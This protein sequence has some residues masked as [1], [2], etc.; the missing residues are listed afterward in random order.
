[1]IFNNVHLNQVF[2]IGLLGVLLLIQKGNA[3]QFKVG[4]SGTWS[5]PS[6][7]NS[8]SYNQWAERSRFQIG[9]TLVFVYQGDKDSVLLVNK[10]D[11]NN[12]NTDNPINKFTDGHTEFKFDH[13]GPHYFI[14]GV[15]D[16]CL[17]NE[18]L[19][20]VV[21]ADRGNRSDAAAAPAPTTTTS[22]PPPPSPTT[23]PPSPTAEVS[24]P[25][26]APAGNEAPSPPAS[27]E[28]NPTPAPSDQTKHKNG[29]SSIVKSFIAHPM[30]AFLGSCLLLVFF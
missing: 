27:V 23:S 9:D 18:K 3:Y 7:P 11:Y 6:D 4:G 14:S 16:N 29:A 28:I 12:C 24:P 2:I 21:M 22:P 5:L 15:K 13:S 1:M 17:K 26:P 8:N 20:V 10:D 30:A 25:S 19:V